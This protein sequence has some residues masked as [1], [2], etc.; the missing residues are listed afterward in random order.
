MVHGDVHSSQLASRDNHMGSTAR[1]MTPTGMGLT[2]MHTVLHMHKHFSQ[3]APE[4]YRSPA[5]TKC[6]S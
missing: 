6:A 4:A 2:G 3:P 5:S 1:G